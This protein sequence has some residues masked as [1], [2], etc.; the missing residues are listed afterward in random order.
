VRTLQ[1]I[2]PPLVR[3]TKILDQPTSPGQTLI[4]WTIQGIASGLGG[5]AAEPG[6]DGH[7]FMRG[8]I[9]LGCETFGVAVRPGCLADLLQSRVDRPQQADSSPA[10]SQRAPSRP[11]DTAS[12]AGGAPAP[13]PPAAPTVGR[14]LAKTLKKLVGVLGGEAGT[15]GSPP[16]VSGPSEPD[17]ARALLDYLLGQ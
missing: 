3:L 9:V 1:A 15:H 6:P 14:P 4:N 11:P 8:T 10:R 16:P 2:A 17:G 13:I 7:H 12:P 5:L